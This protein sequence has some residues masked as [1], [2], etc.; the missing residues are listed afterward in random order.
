MT[1]GVVSHFKKSCVHIQTA[2]A[3]LYTSSNTK[4]YIVIGKFIFLKSL[5]IFLKYFFDSSKFHYLGL[6]DLLHFR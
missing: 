5:F 4:L 1:T 6:F 3:V 2:L